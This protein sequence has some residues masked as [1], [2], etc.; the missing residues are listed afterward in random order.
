MIKY[1]TNVDTS[2]ITKKDFG[3]FWTE[4]Y[5]SGTD[6]S[7]DSL[8]MRIIGDNLYF[9]YTGYLSMTGYTMRGVTSAQVDGV[10][11][12]NSETGEFS[13]KGYV[14][15]SIYF[16]TSASGVS[17]TEFSTNPYNT[18][19]S[20]VSQDFYGNVSADNSEAYGELIFD[21]LQNV[22]E[23]EFFEW[24]NVDNNTAKNKMEFWSSK[25]IDNTG[26]IK[27]TKAISTASGYEGLTLSNIY[28]FPILIHKKDIN[29]KNKIGPFVQVDG[30]EIYINLAII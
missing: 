4:C 9:E 26:D 14:K 30:S 22:E 2:N 8:G 19:I 27:D 13:F 10:E 11:Y 5:K 24:Y 12:I 3:A 6:F 28:K 23:H 15:K 16:Y 7:V 20:A 18:E 25:F 21:D 29:K 1:N 17:F